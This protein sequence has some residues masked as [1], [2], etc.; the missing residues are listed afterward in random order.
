MVSSWSD[1]ALDNVFPYRIV[2]SSSQYNQ[3][4][5]LRLPLVL[6]HGPHWLDLHLLLLQDRDHRVKVRREYREAVR[7]I[8]HCA[9]PRVFWS[10]VGEPSPADGKTSD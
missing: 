7:L 6:V 3:R 10:S 2:H 4:E 1:T 5:D 8:F 9:G